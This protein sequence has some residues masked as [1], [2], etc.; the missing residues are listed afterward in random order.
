MMNLDCFPNLFI[1]SWGFVLIK[2][3]PAFTCHKH[4][5]NTQ[6]INLQT[7]QFA[8]TTSQ[9]YT[10]LLFFCFA[11]SIGLVFGAFTTKKPCFQS[12]VASR[13]WQALHAQAKVAE[14]ST[15]KL[16]HRPHWNNT[17]HHFNAILSK[18]PLLTSSAEIGNVEA[19][20]ARI[21]QASPM[22]AAH[23]K[24]FTCC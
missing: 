22:M 4:V 23:N 12:I 24:R 21:E 13:T 19:G 8:K 20:L 5:N 14:I 1:K 9:L 16:Q 6:E 3:L 17:S 11:K 2:T 15:P 18:S 7:R 10:T